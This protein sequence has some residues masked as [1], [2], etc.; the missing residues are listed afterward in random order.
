[1]S[2]ETSLADTR[3]SWGAPAGTARRSLGVAGKAAGYGFLLLVTAAV[4]YPLCFTVSTALKSPVEYATNELG[5]VHHPTTANFSYLISE[6]QV[7]TGLRNSLI[8]A[9]GAIVL[10]WICG[11]MAGFAVAKLRFRGRIAFFLVVLSSGLVPFQTI[12]APIYAELHQFHLLD[13]YVGLILVYAALGMPITVF[14]FAAYFGGLPS[15]LIEAARLD[16][17]STLGILTRVIVPMAL[18]ALAITGILNFVM[19][20]NDLLTPLLVMQSPDKQLFVVGIAQALGRFQEPTQMA[21][22]IV[23]GLVPLTVTFLFAQ[24]YLIRGVTAGAVR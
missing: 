24:R 18:P 3:V 21:A 10:L 9:L 22:G 12:V 4:L 1:M 16:G 14:I 7:G 6:A 13:S 20:F 15:S 8:V 17:A 2:V 19:V 23:I 11:S 5:L